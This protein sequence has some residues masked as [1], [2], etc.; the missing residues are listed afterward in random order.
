MVFS[1]ANGPLR[2]QEKSCPNKVSFW[3]LL[4]DQGVVT[5][6]VLNYDYTGLGTESDPYIVS[7]IEHDVRN[8]MHF[9]LQRKVTITFVTAFATLI[10]SL[11]SSAYAGSMER[12]IDSFHVGETVAT[13]G[14]SLFVLGFSVGPLVWAPLSEHLGRQ[15]SFFVSFVCLAAFTAGC[16]GAENIHTLLILRFFAGAVGSSP[17]TNAGGV[18]SDMFAARQRGLALCLFAATPYFGPSL[19]PMIGGFL[20]MNGGWRWVQILLAISSGVVWAMIV[21]SVPETYAPV[22]LRKRAQRLSRVTGKYYRST[23]DTQREN[24]PVREQMQKLF[25]RPWVLLLREPIV[26]LLSFYASLIYGTLYMLFAAFPVVYGE[27]RGWNAGVSGLPFLGVMVGTLLGA[28]YTLYDNKRYI[29]AQKR[30]DGFASPEERLYPCMVSALTIPIGLFWFAWTNSASIHWS[31]SVL[32]L[33]PF[34]FGIILIY[35]GIVNY[36]IDSYTIFAASVLAGMSILRYIFGAV[37]PLFTPYMYRA[38]GLHWASSVPAFL[39]TLCFP[40]P[41]LFYKYGPAIRKHCKYA[42]LAQQHL[43]K[44]RN[45]PRTRP[46]AGENN[47]GV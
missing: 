1:S 15:I 35:L 16:A 39:S 45:V 18:V 24:V 28:L 3:R 44:L 29:K 30:G 10:V 4:T 40:L 11:S 7:W 27:N 14:L 25:L 8:P 6:D 41:F 26:L 47:E 13:L 32:A 9:P 46:V 42:A 17:M 12:V 43:Q 31:A 21:I 19:G 36:L 2:T 38:L 37:F 5:Q 20:G 34:G 23:F 22:L 33:V